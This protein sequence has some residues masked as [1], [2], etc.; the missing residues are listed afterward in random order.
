VQE[1]SLDRRPT[2]RP[3]HLPV[4]MAQA[5]VARGPGISEVGA[6]DGAVAEGVVVAVIDV[7]S[8]SAHLLVA[9]VGD[10]VVPLRDESILLG[11]GAAVDAGAIVPAAVADA[12]VP[13]LA[14]Y[15]S[16]ARSLGAR[17]IVVLGTEPFRR[18]ADAAR[19]VATVCEVVGVPMHVLGHDEEGLLTLIGATGGRALAADVVIVDVGGGSSEIVVAGPGRRPVTLGLPIGSARASARHVEHDPPTPGEVEA[20][21]DEARSVLEAAPDVRPAEIVIVGGTASNL[22]KVDPTGLVDGPITRERIDRILASLL[23]LS[24]EAVAER[25]AIRVPRARILVAGAVIV[26]AILDRYGLAAARA[27]D[28]G[29]RDGAAIALA[30]AGPAWRDALPRI[31]MGRR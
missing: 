25:H 23:T 29:I 11:L 15:A 18:A 26:E 21:R 19:I 6:I 14:A 31:A 10:E 3:E 17:E 1:P 28:S 20:L 7:G 13:A 4:A 5:P 30:R 9:R 27:T 22:V 16:V 8:N 12:L 2:H 24:A